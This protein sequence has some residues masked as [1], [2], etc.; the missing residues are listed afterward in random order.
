MRLDLFE[1]VVVTLFVGVTGIL[2]VTGVCVTGAVSFTAV[3]FTAVSFNLVTSV[4][5]VR[6][7]GCPDV[8]AFGGGPLGL[9]LVLSFR[10]CS[11]S[12]IH[13]IRRK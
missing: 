6:A 8:S 13:Q 3:S 11:S 10:P 9:W 12:G 2:S 1:V 5:F 7:R 4:F